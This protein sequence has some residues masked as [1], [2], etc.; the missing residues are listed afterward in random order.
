M[1]K[2]EHEN[3]PIIY[4][5]VLRV[6]PGDVDA[7]TRLKQLLKL[8]LRRF[9]FRCVRVEQVSGDDKPET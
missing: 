7:T 8:A 5:L 1:R 2:L 4:R 6:M 9:G 3:E